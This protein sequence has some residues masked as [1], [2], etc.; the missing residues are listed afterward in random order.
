LKQLQV[1]PVLELAAEQLK[2]IRLSV[3]LDVV[4]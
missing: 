4:S 2:R 3:S 1:D